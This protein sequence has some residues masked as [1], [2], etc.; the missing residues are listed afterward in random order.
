MAR[1]PEVNELVVID[2]VWVLSVPTNAAA[3]TVDNAAAV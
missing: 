3:V 1:G 2:P